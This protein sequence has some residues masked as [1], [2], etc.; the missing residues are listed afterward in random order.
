MY[1]KNKMKVLPLFANKHYFMYCSVNM[2]KT[3]G[4]ILNG[5]ILNRVKA[6]LMKKCVC[7]QKSTLVGVKGTVTRQAFE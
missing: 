6:E 4:C 2:N 5:N 7:L 1:D 3:A